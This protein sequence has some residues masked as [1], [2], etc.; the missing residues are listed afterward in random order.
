MSKIMLIKPPLY[1]DVLF[2]PVRSS[3][4]LGLWYIGSYLEEIGHEV[5]MLDSVLEA[6]GNR[7]LI[8][9][10][11]MKAGS[12]LTYEKAK[13][14]IQNEFLELDPEEFVGKYSPFLW[15]A[16]Q[17]RIQRI[18]MDDDDIIRRIGGE[19]PS[20]IGLEM[21]ASCNHGSAVS[22]ARKIKKDFP[23]ITI[24][25]GGAHATD[26]SETVI[27]DS[28]GAIDIAVRGDGQYVL[29][30]LLDG[31]LP[32]SGIAYMVGGIFIDK[33]E[34]R[35]MRMDEFSILKPELM[36]HVDLP[37]PALH[38]FDTGG[39]KYTDIMFSRGCR[40]KCDFCVAGSK[41]YRY[42]RLGLDKAEKTLSALKNA[43]Y[44][45]LILQ[46]DDILSDKGYFM[47]V[48]DLAKK[49]GFTWQIN[50]G[51]MLEDLD[52]V[53]VDKIISNGNCSSFY[54]PVNPRRYD[55]TRSAKRIKDSYQS[56]L[57]QLRRLKGSGIY[58]YTSCI[59]GTHY[60]K[61]ED[62]RYEIGIF[63]DMIG[64]GYVDQVLI[65]PVSILPGTK[66]HAMFRDDIIEPDDWQ[67]YSIMIPHARTEYMGI[68]EVETEFVRAH[69]E[70]NSVQKNAGAWGTP[71]PK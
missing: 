51:V 66:N 39:R 11:G 26:V 52:E 71:F 22:L 17:R 65:F 31:R 46:D 28:G 61:K 4:S 18:G 7:Q 1:L 47:D 38:T 50:S 30:D 36:E 13:E 23:E 10:E 40:L 25:A 49:H 62:I 48:L 24:F 57:D 20:Y 63:K 54:A 41:D 9:P 55:T 12:R 53:I 60:Q 5:K 33:G 43:G 27:R 29:E 3:Q 32:A 59:I 70:L 69:K 42:S 56:Q 35:R 44:Q 45:E 15:G 2:D 37:K 67:G 68:M 8:G 21:F 14:H 58:L 34:S 19:S 6:S 64:Q 16:Q